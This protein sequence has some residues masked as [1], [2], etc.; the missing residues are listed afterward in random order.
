MSS[1]QLESDRAIGLGEKARDIVDLMDALEEAWR[2]ARRTRATG[3][4]AAAPTRPAGAAPNAATPVIAAAELTRGAYRLP[5]VGRSS[6]A[7]AKLAKAA[8][9]RAG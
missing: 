5:V 9:A 6:R 2:G 4:A 7:W 1:A 3:R 8:S